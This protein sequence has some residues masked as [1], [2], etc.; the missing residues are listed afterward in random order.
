LEKLPSKDTERQRQQQF[1]E[2]LHLE[3]LLQRAIA[4][5]TGMSSD[6]YRSDSKKSGI[7]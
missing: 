6:D 2:Q 1:V 5:T 3:Q 7:P 4:P